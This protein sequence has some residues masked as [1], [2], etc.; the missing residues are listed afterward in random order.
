MISYGTMN[1]HKTLH[2]LLVRSAENYPDRIAV[3]E[4][5]HGAITYRD[6][7][8]LSDQLRDRLINL[9]I[10]P[11]DRVGIY[12]RKSIDAVASIFGILKAGAAYVPVDPGAPPARNAYIFGDC[13]V[14]AIII[15]NRFVEKLC[16]EFTSQNE[17]PTLIVLDGTGSGKSLKSA[18]EQTNKDHPTLSASLELPPDNL[19]YILYTSGSTGKPKGVML[20]HH[21]ALGFVDWCSEVFEPSELDR[22]SSHAPFHFDLSILD[23]YV[24]LKHGATLVL[25]EEE[26]G[27]DPIRLARL[28][29]DKRISIWYSTPSILSFLAQYGKLDQYRFPDL[30]LVLFAGEVFPI[31]HLRLLKDLLPQPKYFNLYGPTETNVCTYFEIPATIPA[32]QTKPFPIGEACTHYKKRIKIVDEQGQEVEV[33]QEGELIASGPGVMQGYWNLP[34][35]TA[36][37]FLVDASGQRWYKTGDVVVQDEDGNYLYV[38]RRDRMVKKRGYRVELGEIE[39]G[40]YKHPDVK[41]AAV[42]AISSDENGVQVKAFLSFKNVQ[43]PSRIALKRFCAENLPN[44][45]IPDFFSFLESLPKTSTDKIDYQTLKTID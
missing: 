11:G 22:F 41:E 32:D 20:S 3:E 13:T 43:N 29:L 37:A 10:R 45:M 39:A 16:A 38:S 23:I 6:L 7:D 28:M 27:K 9:G 24:S 36:N 21:N 44:Y 25:I 34:E 5:D 35:R 40:L 2:Q 1:N 19:A 8:Q 12:L 17:L 33:G 4:T 14:K 31:K 42:I 26:I 18:L 30:R 15:E